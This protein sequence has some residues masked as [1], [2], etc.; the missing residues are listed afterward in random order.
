MTNAAGMRNG[1][2]GVS[3]FF[4]ITSDATSLPAA[5][6]YPAS[7]G[8][9]P[10]ELED[11]ANAQGLGFQRAEVPHVHGA[12]PLRCRNTSEQAVA[13]ANDPA[14][15]AL[16]KKA[17]SR[18]ECSDK[19]TRA[20]VKQRVKLF[21]HLLRLVDRATNLL[22][23]LFNQGLLELYLHLKCTEVGMQLTRR[24][25]RGEMLRVPA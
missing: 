17:L 20:I 16:P 19:P 7:C 24:C 23:T 12:L 1:P 10:L 2:A 18:S 5:L 22:V 13:P 11:F 15:A 21:P 25:D 9:W 14:D 4:F 8:T 3:S 6:P